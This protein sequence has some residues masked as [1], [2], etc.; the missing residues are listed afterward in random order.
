MENWK[1][2][3]ES[4]NKNANF[5]LIRLFIGPFGLGFEYGTNTIQLYNH[6]KLKFSFIWAVVGFKLHLLDP[7]HPS[8]HCHEVYNSFD[9]QI[10]S[11]KSLIH[12]S[13]LKK[14]FWDE[15]SKNAV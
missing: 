10:S 8:Y 6:L 3:D 7:H 11:L 5:I 14:R 2:H 9:I 1:E 15:K 4:L 12:S 13:S